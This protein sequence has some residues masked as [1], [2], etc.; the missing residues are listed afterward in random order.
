LAIP[1]SLREFDFAIPL[2]AEFN[3]ASFIGYTG[4]LLPFPIK[5]FTAPDANILRM[6]AERMLAFA[7]KGNKVI[8]FCEGGHGRT[9][10]VLAT[11]IGLAE[12]D[13]EDPIV[14]IRKRHC[15][16]AC[17]TNDQIRAV[18]E[19][20]RRPL[21]DKYKT[22]GGS[23]AGFIAFTDKQLDGLTGALGVERATVTPKATNAVPGVGV[24]TIRAEG[25]QMALPALPAPP[26]PPKPLVVS[27]STV[28]EPLCKCPRDSVAFSVLCPIQAHADKAQKARGVEAT[29]PFAFAGEWPS[30]Q[31][32]RL[33]T[34]LPSYGLIK[35]HKTVTGKWPS[36]VHPQLG[37]RCAVCLGFEV[38]PTRLT[39]SHIADLAAIVHHLDCDE[40]NTYVPILTDQRISYLQKD[41]P[42]LWQK[43]VEKRRHRRKRL[44]RKANRS[45]Q[46]S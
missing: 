24:V 37:L 11:C 7:R 34:P 33:L 9:G 16:K 3:L 6:F 2:G 45:N 41:Q 4:F 21:P 31:W 29:D 17:E 43:Y 8:T 32:L 36:W 10:L 39:V 5:D 44:R 20:L 22:G 40:I 15:D 30:Q 1:D 13:V 42:A 28:D 12:P 27:S 18:F 38:D 35:E 25:Q 19:A 26:P 23:K 14:A 46:V